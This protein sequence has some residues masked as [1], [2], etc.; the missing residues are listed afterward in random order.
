[1]AT[2]G[3]HLHVLEAPHGGWAH[4]LGI[5]LG[6]LW[7]AIEESAL[8]IGPHAAIWPWKVWQSCCWTPAEVPEH[9]RRLSSLN[10]S[11]GV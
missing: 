3:Q 2:S 8:I 9:G 10:T 7:G 11:K 1:M 5:R 4:I 6:V